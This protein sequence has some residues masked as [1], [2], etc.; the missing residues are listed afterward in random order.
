MSEDLVEAVAAELERIGADP[1][2]AGERDSIVA[3][4]E[5]EGWASLGASELRRDLY[6]YGRSEVILQR[7]ATLRDGS[8]PEAVRREFHTDVPDSLRG[9]G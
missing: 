6:W 5:R 8:G 2:H 4:D 7:L 9:S 1:A 3:N